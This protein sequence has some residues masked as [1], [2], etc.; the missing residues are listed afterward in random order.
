[1]Q[2]AGRITLSV[3]LSFLLLPGGS[4]LP[5]AEAAT[6]PTAGATHA[7]MSLPVWGLFHRAEVAAALTGALPQAPVSVQLTPV[8]VPGSGQ[9]GVNI[10]YVVGSGFPSGT[11]A[12]GSVSISFAGTCG[13]AVVAAASP[14]A[15]QA[16]VGTTRRFQLP[17]PG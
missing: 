8:T 14:T 10:V 7:G 16:P 17:L 6:M 5:V 12:P 4:W 11:I 9:A 13:G 3:L 1:M 15:V 2:M